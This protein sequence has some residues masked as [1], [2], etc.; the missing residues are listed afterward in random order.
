MLDWK[1]GVVRA[2]AEIRRR[3][4]KTSLMVDIGLPRFL[5]EKIRGEKGNIKRMRIMQVE[6]VSFICHLRL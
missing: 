3:A 2:K 1:T 4:A 6:P 5:Q